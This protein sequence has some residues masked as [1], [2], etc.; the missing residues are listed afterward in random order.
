MTRKRRV[1]VPAHADPV[2]SDSLEGVDLAAME[3]KTEYDVVTGF[4]QL[5]HDVLSVGLR[6]DLLVIRHA[7]D[8][9]KPPSTTTTASFRSWLRWDCPSNL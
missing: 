7:V 4:R 9:W 2:P 5:E 1:M 8:D 3:W 6:D